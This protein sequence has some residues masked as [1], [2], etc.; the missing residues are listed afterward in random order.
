[1]PGTRRRWRNRVRPATEVLECRCLL[2]GNPGSLDLSFGTDGIVI[3]PIS[4]QDEWIR[5]LAA[6]P[7][8]KIL[9]VG[10]QAG[11]ILVA[12]FD[13]DG[14]LDRTF[15]QS[16]TAVASF[17]GVE[18]WVASAE[19]NPDGTIVVVGHTRRTATDSLA[20]AVAQLTEAGIPDSAFDGDG[21][22]VVDI[23][24]GDDIA[25]DV[26]VDEDGKVVVAGTANENFAARSSDFA[27]VRLNSDGSRDP[28]FGDSG[29]T[30]TAHSWHDVARAVAIQ[31]DGRIV[32]GGFSITGSS[33]LS[34][35][36]AVSRYE[37]SG[38]PDPSFGFQRRDFSSRI[39]PPTFA[40]H[41]EIQALAIQ[42]DGKIVATGQISRDFG[43]G[44]QPS[45][46]FVARF[47]STGSLDEGFQG[48]WTSTTV[49]IASR[50]VPRAVSIQPDSKI[51]V[52][53]Q[54][55]HRGGANRF[56]LARFDPDGTLDASFVDDDS[57]T[58]LGVVQTSVGS[59]DSLGLG[60]HFDAV[61]RILVG[62]YTTSPATGR[63]FAMARYHAFDTA[64]V[65]VVLNGEEI[66]SGTTTPIDLGQVVIG[67]ASR[68]TTFTVRNTGNTPLTFGLANSSVVQL[69]PGFLLEKDLGLAIAPGQEDTFVVA[70]ESGSLGLRQGPITFETNDPDA[71]PFTFIVRGEVFPQLGL[72]RWW[73]TAGDPEMSVTWTVDVP[74]TQS[75]TLQVT[76]G[77]DRWGL[78]VTRGV[79]IDGVPSGSLSSAGKLTIPSLTAGLH[80]IAIEGFR[81]P[82]HAAVEPIAFRLTPSIVGPEILL[83]SL[84]IADW[85]QQSVSGN[86]ALN[87][88]MVPFADARELAAALVP[89]FHF[90]TT[91]GE[92]YNVPLD[93]QEVFNRLDSRAITSP[94]GDRDRFVDLGTFDTI[95]PMLPA[96]ST[97]AVYTSV[98]LC[99]AGL[100]ELGSCQQNSELA[101]TF[102]L[103]YPYSDWQDHGGFNK[104]E[105]DW[106]VVTIFLDQTTP[107]T[108][109]PTDIAVGQHVSV[110]ALKFFAQLDGGDRA[111]WESV[112][113][114]GSTRANIYVGLGGHANYLGEGSTWWLTPDGDRKKETHRGSNN[115]FLADSSQVQVL[116][117]VGSETMPRWSLFSGRWGHPDLGGPRVLGDAAPRGPAFIDDRWTNPWEHAADFSRRDQSD[118][119]GIEDAEEAAAP[120]NGDGNADGTPDQDQ[121]AVASLLNSTT[122]TFVTIQTS[123]GSLLNVQAVSPPTPVPDNVSLPV[124]AFQFAIDGVP[125]GG[126]AVAT[127]TLHG[128][129]SASTFHVFGPTAS[130]NAPH[131][132]EFLYD[133]GTD[134]GAKYD[135]LN[136]VFIVHYVDGGRGDADGLANGTIVDPGAP[137]LRKIVGNV[138]VA[139]QRGRLRLDGDAASNAVAI[140]QTDHFAYKV[141]GLSG[142]TL[143]GNED[144][145]IIT[146]ARWGLRVSLNDGADRLLIDDAAFRG[147]TAINTGP[148]ADLI[149]FSKATFQGFTSIA[150]SNGNDTIN[151]LDSLFVGVTFFD[152]GDGADSTTLSRSALRGIGLFDGGHGDDELDILRLS[153]RGALRHRHFKTVRR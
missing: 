54:T 94:N 86:V 59:G 99:N 105:G 131:W 100:A 142:T 28:D 98:L 148:G 149:S 25:Y 96:D 126:K 146:G 5:D 33:N 116:P 106:E 102:H 20:F 112:V 69:P 90:A 51:V 10:T 84:F 26:A 107:N 13:E 60:M 82:T 27:V 133:A 65:A 8:G 56:M 109:T 136:N 40:S 101:V 76:I 83:R 22:A 11:D 122:P 34:V 39:N 57:E 41:E 49:T 127:Y 3:E 115:A 35:D 47:D 121:S 23:T 153:L 14:S 150:T 88:T 143:N 38:Q 32:V 92:Q 55:V 67:N 73:A 118:T 18:N 139:V 129:E 1:M 21:V 19:I 37:A 80:E 95:S 151:A 103:F 53:G 125:P 72:D 91:L 62:G 81:V 7:D 15:G 58:E 114:T 108:W 130:N 24:S 104:H 71:N 9:A 97:E 78:G 6:L 124:G 113:P 119:D 89:K 45:D 74:T 48:G 141:T 64:E 44:Y 79:R 70:L 52:A 75:H 110:R 132:F 61:G 137:A 145:L 30:V 46:L 147:I 123:A 68:S 144:P 29:V 4:G 50:D 12:R 85:S 66:Q 135:A 117:R 16:G 93:V 42:D 43:S 111:A 17:G 120:N 152:L 63:D 77:G 128:G 36:I 31:P 134:T 138:A 140:T 87:G 2:A